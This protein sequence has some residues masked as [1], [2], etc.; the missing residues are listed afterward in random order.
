MSWWTSIKAVLGF[1]ASAAGGATGN[2]LAAV[3]AGA[4]MVTEVSRTAR[5]ASRGATERGIGAEKEKN[6]TAID[7]AVKRA[8]GGTLLL[9]GGLLLA[10]SMGC[11]SVPPRDSGMSTG[12]VGRLLARPDFDP[13]AK[14]APEWVRD[15]LK[16][17][18]SLEA[19]L[20]RERA[21]SNQVHE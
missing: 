7:E 17:V 4:Q 2:P 10:F 9:L 18:N 3:T 11:A 15:S 20:Q 8:T 12:N 13:A 21:R 19:D 14:A 5:E 16:T 1:G 6:D